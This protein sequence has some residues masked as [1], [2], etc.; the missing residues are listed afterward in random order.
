MKKSKFIFSALLG[1]FI[2]ILIT[3]C[4]EDAALV[5]P[6]TIENAASSSQL[7]SVNNCNKPY[8]EVSSYEDG[9]HVI[10]NLIYVERDYNKVNDLDS[11]E[12]YFNHYTDIDN[13]N[14][15]ATQTFDL[16]GRKYKKLG[17]D[18][19]VDFATS[20]GMVSNE[21][22][23]YLKQFRQDFVNFIELDQPSFSEYEQYLLNKG[24]E[25]DATSSLCAYDKYIG[26]IYHVTLMGIGKYLYDAQ[27]AL[28]L[29]TN[30]IEV[31]SS[32]EG[33]WQNLVCGTGGGIVAGVVGVA[34][35]IWKWGKSIFTGEKDGKDVELI[36]ALYQ[37]YKIAVDMWNVG[38][39]FYDWCCDTLYN[40][41]ENCGAPTGC[42]KSDL[43]CNSHELNI[44][45]PG[46]YTIT[47][48]GTNINTNPTNALTPTPRLV[49]SVPNP[50]NLSRILGDV[51][52]TD[53]GGNSQEAFDF[54]RQV[55][56]NYQL[57]TPYWNNSPPSSGSVGQS[58]QFSVANAPGAVDLYSIS[59]TTTSG[60]SITPITSGM[61]YCTPTT[62]GTQTITVTYT[63]DC[64]GETSSLQKTINVN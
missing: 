21:L 20:Q 7:G 43:G 30:L 29:Q 6:N 49:V 10:E 33:F 48:W 45:G 1:M 36:E 37:I 26:K 38:V 56:T 8:Y 61:Y 34:V 23:F 24:E 60:L 14:L 27:N 51:T 53:D 44:V 19:Y 55:G 63:H 12:K 46:L 17:H 57:P 32:C 16:H 5:E 4:N 13:D 64:S 28:S 42:W 47:T 50:Q 58:F 11:K 39:S 41:L 52:C 3:S 22:N 25:L 54:F 35:G 18:G 40:D 15:M 59:V 9:A 2:M 62:S 31:R